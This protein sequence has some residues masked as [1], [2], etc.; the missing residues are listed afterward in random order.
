MS[1]SP[2]IASGHR[3]PKGLVSRNVS[4]F[5]GRSFVSEKGAPQSGQ[6]TRQAFRQCLGTA[7]DASS[8]TYRSAQG[9]QIC[10]VLL[11]QINSADLRMAPGG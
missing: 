4:P 6:V 5:S 7:P 10:G 8:R 1:I 11:R 3:R 2:A 9:R